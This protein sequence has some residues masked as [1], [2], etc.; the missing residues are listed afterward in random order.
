[1]SSIVE[2]SVAVGATAA[3]CYAL[4]KLSRGT[5]TARRRSG[6]EGGSYGDGGGPN[7]AGS[8]SNDGC[9]TEGGGAC[10]AGGDGGGG[11]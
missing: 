7:G 1:M 6:S 10:D 11:D 4:I 2:G 5:S 3:L 8:T 9:A